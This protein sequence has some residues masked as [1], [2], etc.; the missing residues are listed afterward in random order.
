M[1]LNKRKYSIT[2][3]EVYNYETFKLLHR[4][5][6]LNLSIKDQLSEYRKRSRQLRF[7]QSVC[8]CVQRTDQQADTSE[9]VGRFAGQNRHTTDLFRSVRPSVDTSLW[10]AI[11][12]M[13]VC[14]GTGRK[15][16]KSY[17]YKCFLHGGN[18]PQS[19]NGIMF[20]VIL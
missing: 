4:N 13:Y 14:R 9:K 19:F 6:G 17:F 7:P 8:V 2:K 15:G 11:M 5:K 1:T 10:Y 12:L 3:N 20:F 16:I 18:S